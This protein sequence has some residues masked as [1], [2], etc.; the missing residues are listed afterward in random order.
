MHTDHSFV[1]E[2]DRFVTLAGKLFSL[3]YLISVNVDHV[4]QPK[5]RM[6]LVGLRDIQ[7]L[8]AA[9]EMHVM[10]FVQR[11]PVKR[12]YD[13]RRIERKRRR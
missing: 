6:D 1:G 5:I 9:E 10:Q 3:L 12:L 4:T 2:R 13:P 8:S 11:R 7:L